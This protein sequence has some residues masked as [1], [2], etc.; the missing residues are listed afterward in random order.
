MKKENRREQILHTLQTRQEPIRAAQLA[1][2]FHV[3]RQS[4][5]GDIALLR[6][7]GYDIT[8]T[9]RGYVIPDSQPQSIYQIACKHDVDTMKDELY[10]IVDFGCKI[11]DVIVEHPIYG[12]LTGTLQLSSRY[13]VDQFIQ[14][15]QKLD[16]EPLSILTQ[17][18]H[19][20]TISCPGEETYHRVIKALQ[21][22]HIL[23]NEDN[24]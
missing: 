4:I 14:N 5:V 6:A 7:S 2:Q 13:D 15:I 3:S 21:D 22:K 8:A 11:I 9:P 12:E 16:A 18:I 23:L 1:K 17:G 24:T 19:L 20:H 10:T